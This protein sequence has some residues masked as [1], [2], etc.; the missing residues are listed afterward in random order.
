[1]EKTTVIY[2]RVST[3]RQADEGVSLD[4]QEAACRA[5]CERKQLGDVEVY[6]DAGFSGKDLKRP[7]LQDLLAKVAAGEVETVLVTKLDRLSR[8]TAQ[9][10]TLVSET[11][12]GHTGFV[13]VEQDIDTTTP[14]GKAMLG[15]VAVFAGLERDMV[16]E[17]TREAAAHCRAEGLS[18]GPRPFGYRRSSDPADKKLHRHPDE[19][20]VLEGMRAERA[21][22]MTYRAI[23]N[24]LTERGVPT[25]TG[26]ATWYPETVRAVLNR[27]RNGDQGE[28]ATS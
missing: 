5:Y 16:A 21:A 13:T 28:E 24:G 27:K 15:M 11:L 20:P 9:A 23:A 6:S 3:Q 10:L 7:A 14:M 1:M 19:F 2:T 4:A 25:K 8:N 12:D 17:R 26:K 22:G 18:F